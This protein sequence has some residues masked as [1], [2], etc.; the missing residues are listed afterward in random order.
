MGRF[1]DAWFPILREAWELDIV[2]ICSGNNNPLEPL[3]DRSPQ[4]YGRFNNALITVDS[5][6]FDGSPWPGVR[7]CYILTVTKAKTEGLLTEA[8]E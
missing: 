8:F 1:S 5:M 3:G 4:R 7:D 2:T 6:N